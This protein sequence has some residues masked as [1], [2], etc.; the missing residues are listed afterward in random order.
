MP[1]I[2]WTINQIKLYHF[3]I[4]KQIEVSVFHQLFKLFDLISIIINFTPV[5]VSEEP[6]LPWMPHRIKILL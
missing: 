3:F 1:C 4:R 6:V 5:V 2:H